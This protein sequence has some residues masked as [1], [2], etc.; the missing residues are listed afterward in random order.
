MFKSMFFMVMMFVPSMVIAD[1]V[2]PDPA[3]PLSGLMDSVNYWFV[4][5]SELITSFCIVATI[6]VRLIGKGKKTMLTIDNW[7]IKIL[8]FAPTIGQNPITKEMKATLE[9]QKAKI[10]ELESKANGK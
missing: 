3:N 10:E 1:T 6:T 5:A 9:Q 7:L 4:I 2:I 8:H